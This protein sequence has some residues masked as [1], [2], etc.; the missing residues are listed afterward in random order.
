MNSADCNALLKKARTRGGKEHQQQQKLKDEEHNKE[1]EKQQREEKIKKVKYINDLREAENFKEEHPFVT[2]LNQNTIFMVQNHYETVN[3]TATK[4]VKEEWEKQFL[5]VTRK[6]YKALLLASSRKRIS[7][8]TSMNQLLE[9]ILY[10]TGSKY[11]LLMKGIVEIPSTDEFGNSYKIV[12]PYTHIPSQNSFSEIKESMKNGTIYALE[13]I[14]LSGLEFNDNIRKLIAPNFLRFR[15]TGSHAF[16]VKSYIDGKPLINNSFSSKLQ[17]PGHPNTRTL[18]TIPFYYGVECLGTIVLANREDGYTEEM[19]QPLSSLGN[20]IALMMK[21][22][23]HLVEMERDEVSYASLANFTLGDGKT[24]KSSQSQDS[25]DNQSLPNSFMSD[26]STSNNKP[27]PMIRRGRRSSISTLTEYQQRNG[28]IKPEDRME[29]IP[30]PFERKLSCSSG[31]S[32]S[33]L[34]TYPISGTSD[35]IDEDD[36]SYYDDEEIEMLK[37]AELSLALFKSVQDS[38]VIIDNN[39]MVT[40]M[41]PSARKFFGVCNNLFNVSSEFH[42][43]DLIPDNSSTELVWNE[44]CKKNGFSWFKGKTLAKCRTV[45]NEGRTSRIVPIS[46]SVSSF[47]FQN[48]TYYAL[49]ITDESSK[50]EMKEKMRFIAYLSHEI[51]NPLFVVS[52]GVTSLLDHCKQ[53]HLCNGHSGIKDFKEPDQLVVNALFSSMEFITLLINDTI[54]LTKLESGNMKITEAT[55]NIRE[56]LNQIINILKMYQNENKSIGFSVDSN[57]PTNLHTDPTKLQQ[58]L[59]NLLTNSC[60]YTKK[61]FIHLHCSMK[62]HICED[63]GIKSPY[64]DFE[65]KDSGVGI[66]ESELPKMFKIYRRFHRKEFEVTGSGIGLALSKLLCDILKAKITVESTLGKGSTFVVSLPYKEAKEPEKKKEEIE[67]KETPA[68]VIVKPNPE[69]FL[70]DKRV[71]I[72]DDSDMIRR[73]LKHMLK[74]CVCEE[75]EDGQ[76]AILKW[77]QA[78]NEGN[79]FDLILLDVLMPVLSGLE[80]TKILRNEKGA[81]T[82]IIALTGNSLQEE[83]NEMLKIGANIVLIKPVKRMELLE[84]I[85]EVLDNVTP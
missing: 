27:S 55:F 5:E 22:Y 41:N 13:A 76:E 62:E 49:I 4:F 34:N 53:C 85:V 14:A 78:K 58:I 61:G 68:V 3:P 32:T 48:E 67:T 42:I 6:T 18:I 31:T 70:K 17:P 44:L 15:V 10:I 35:N 8:W 72:V 12:K 81:S 80:A 54:D 20:S 23:D 57:V 52:S 77:E 69:T 39:L 26:Q 30:F 24:R 82:P 74:M 65:I 1:D 19:I 33:S 43:T 2:D 79:P 51:R 47:F 75:A 29:E 50:E 83:V 37:S 56:K 60:K 84:K 63:T 25:I 16:F 11:G 45:E 64:I 40:T 9:Q 21:L 7:E 73:L 46:L 36:N 38:I 66:A 59:M 28:I 71:L